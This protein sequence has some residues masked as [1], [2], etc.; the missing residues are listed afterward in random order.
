M[1]LLN[2]RIMGF[3]LL[4]PEKPR[5]R[6]YDALDFSMGTI[7]PLWVTNFFARRRARKMGLY[8]KPLEFEILKA[9][10]EESKTTQQM[11][12][13]NP[14]MCRGYNGVTAM[15]CLNYLEKHNLVTV[16]TVERDRYPGMPERFSKTAKVT[17]TERG[18]RVYNATK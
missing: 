1:A 18:R 4:P 17:V 6:Y 11:F 7:F 8:F 9:V 16:E 15:L 13:Q 10:Q 2:S 14:I 5:F 3:M 12:I